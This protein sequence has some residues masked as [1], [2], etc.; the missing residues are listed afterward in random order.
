MNLN[1]FTYLLNKPE[2]INDK[3]TEYLG[4]VVN[5]FPY[6]QGAKALRLKG[7]YNQDSFRYNYALKVAACHTTDRSVL[8]D[9]ITSDSFVASQKKHYESKINEIKNLEVTDFELIDSLKPSKNNQNTLEQSIIS[10]INIAAGEENKTPIAT[11]EE[12]LKIN[13]PLDFSKNEKHSFQEWLQISRFKPITRENEL[14]NQTKLSNS[15]NDKNTKSALI[16]KFIEANPK[17]SP[18]NPNSDFS[19]STTIQKSEDTF[20][21]TETLARVYL[22]QK[23]YDRAI[24]A[25]EILILKYPEKSSLFANL[26]SEIDFLKQNNK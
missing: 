15:K 19:Y 2:A 13:K 10:S 12:K 23:K 26:I 24:Q 9:F 22:E 11:T 25:Y 5:E 4:E 20:L 1:D 21:M 17:I 8:F 18:I 14:E 16:D 3:Q 6:F 7:L